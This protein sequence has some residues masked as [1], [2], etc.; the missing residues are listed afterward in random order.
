MSS[1]CCPS[2][3]G[4]LGQDPGP[5]KK[6]GD[7]TGAEGRG[8]DRGSG[9]PS[10]Q[11]GMDRGGSGSGQEAAL[12]QAFLFVYYGLILQAEENG[13]A[14]RTHLRTLLET[15]HQWPKQ[16]EVRAEASARPHT[17]RP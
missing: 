9:G 15:S 10:G 2:L 17:D 4:H 16:R 3:D 11:M 7:P 12:P 6:R 8:L 13:N 1:P 14:V 5:Q